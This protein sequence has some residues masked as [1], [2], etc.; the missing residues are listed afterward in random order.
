MS[1]PFKEEHPLGKLQGVWKE[2]ERK[3]EEQEKEFHKSCDN[4]TCHDRLYL[5]SL[6]RRWEAIPSPSR[7]SIHSTRHRGS[8]EATM[9]L[10]QAWISMLESGDIGRFFRVM[11]LGLFQLCWN[12]TSGNTSRGDD[13]F[14]SPLLSHIFIKTWNNGS[15]C[16]SFNRP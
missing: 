8:R 11:V 10:I 7:C 16:Y 15:L 2:R 6:L 9:S 3:E 1:K 13:L 5:S 14:P 4:E 12:M